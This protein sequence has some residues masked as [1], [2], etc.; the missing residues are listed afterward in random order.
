M[1]V[2]LERVLF[3]EQAVVNITVGVSATVKVTVATAQREVS[4]LLLDRV[5]TQL[6]GE[7]PGLVA[8]RRLLWRV[9]V[10]LG[11]PCCGPVGQVGKIDV[12]AQSGEILFS[13][14]LL[15]E[16]AERGDAMARRALSA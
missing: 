3:P 14:Q 9:P 15:D 11:L 13:Q 7:Q 10:W 8:G 16:I 1:T 5:G 12:D 2:E 6:N 4:K